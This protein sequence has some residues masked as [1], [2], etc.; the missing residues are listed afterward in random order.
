M[1]SNFGSVSYN[2]IVSPP[3]ASSA[4]KAKIG[5]VADYRDTT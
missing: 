3:V 1:K 2:E 5:Y 4:F